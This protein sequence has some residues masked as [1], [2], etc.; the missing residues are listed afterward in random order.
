M[1]CIRGE[2]RPSSIAKAG[3]GLFT[4]DF[5]PK[6][7]IV[8]IY[9]SNPGDLII[10]EKSYLEKHPDPTSEEWDIFVKL[11][12]SYYIGN[13]DHKNLEDYI[14]HSDFPNLLY[15]CGIFIAVQDIEIGEELTVDYRYF[16]KENAHEIFKING[17]PIIGLSNKESLLRSSQKLI[18]I[19]ESVDDLS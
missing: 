9:N 4:L 2:V 7:K 15:H 12:G 6:G 5:L 8:I 19:L 1:L 13:Y 16:L 10:D 17:K 11:I 3:Q 14:N 18:E